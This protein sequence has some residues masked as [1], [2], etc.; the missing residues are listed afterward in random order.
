M[1]TCNIKG[2]LMW[3]NFTAW[4]KKNCCLGDSYM[5]APRRSRKCQIPCKMVLLSSMCYT[6]NLCPKKYSV[7]S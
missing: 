7:T 1:D 5:L 2:Y 4:E 3:S 6:M